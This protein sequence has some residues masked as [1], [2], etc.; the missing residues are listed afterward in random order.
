MDRKV[1]YIRAFVEGHMVRED[2]LNKDEV[3]AIFG[4]VAAPARKP[5]RQKLK[6]A[7]GIGKRL[8][9]KQGQLLFKGT[10]G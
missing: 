9:Q 6:S 1:I 4:A 3:K 8:Q 7:L 5:L 10:P 2:R